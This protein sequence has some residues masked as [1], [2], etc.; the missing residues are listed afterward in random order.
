M[1]SSDLVY[2]LTLRLADHPTMQDAQHSIDL[3]A[4]T[5]HIL[6]RGGG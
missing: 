4:E 3:A 5:T 6:E 2:E 1:I